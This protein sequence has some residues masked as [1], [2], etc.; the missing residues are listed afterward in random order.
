ML[1]VGRG[2]ALGE[3]VESATAAR[4][5]LTGAVGRLAP[6]VPVPVV[7]ELGLVVVLVPGLW[8]CQVVAH[9]RLEL[10]LDGVVLVLVT[11]VVIHV[12]V[13][14]IGQAVH[15]AVPRQQPLAVGRHQVRQHQLVLDLL[16]HREEVATT[17]DVGHPDCAELEDVGDVDA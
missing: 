17:H 1:G 13:A 11:A 9:F 3:P 4:H 5:L 2:A 12:V 8:R 16:R 14:V 15:D 10:C 7:E 6:I